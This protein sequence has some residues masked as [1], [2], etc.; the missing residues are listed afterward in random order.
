M[1]DITF[2]RNLCVRCGKC[3]KTCA[4]G[5]LRMTD[6][7]PA[8]TG[9]GAC[10]GCLQCAAICPRQAV[11]ADGHSPIEERPDDPVEALIMSR[12]SVRHFKPEPPERTLIEWAL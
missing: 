2:D 8:A 3:V 7:G 12:R 6:D 9:R 10:M 1:V 5:H 4:M 11:L